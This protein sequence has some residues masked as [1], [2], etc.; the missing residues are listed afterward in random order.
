MRHHESNAVEDIGVT[1]DFDNIIFI[2]DIREIPMINRV[3]ILH[4]LV[5][6][7]LNVHLSIGT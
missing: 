3:R 1:I 2:Q 6:P 5:F 4:K 7:L